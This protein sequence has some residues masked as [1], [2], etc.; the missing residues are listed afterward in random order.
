[1]IHSI[2]SHKLFKNSFVYIATDIVNSAIP[3]LLLPLL[4]T[5]LTPY[6]YGIVSM[7]QVL[8]AVTSILVGLNTN[9]AI[10]VNFFK[11][12]KDDL[13]VYISNVVAICL[14]S[15]L[16]LVVAVLALKPYV[17]KLVDFPENWLLLIAG[18]SIFIVI[19]TINLVLW[20]SE[21]RPLPY[22]LMQI[23]MTTLNLLLSLYFILILEWKWQGRLA[24]IIIANIL[25]GIVSLLFVY[26]RGYLKFSIH[27]AFI[28]DALQIGL[29]LVPHALAGWINSA[30]G[31]VFISS[32]VGMAAT[33]SYTVGYQVGMIM[34][35]LVTS[36]NKA[37]SPFLF[38][39]L[40]EDRPTVNLKI[41]KF[42]YCYLVAVVSLAL[43]LSIITPFLFKL[44]IGKEFQ[45]ASKY[46]AWILLG[47]AAN[48]MY[49]MGGLYLMYIK[50]T[51]IF[52]ATT[53]GAA[54]IN[55][56][57]NY[58]LI[59]FNGPLGAAQAMTITSVI[60]CC[61]IW[62]MSVRAYKMPWNLKLQ[63]KEESC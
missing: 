56:V 33:G 21:Q 58:F 48:G 59:K 16:I 7:G 11:I 62:F 9:T 45:S 55:I 23:A 20:Q 27:R 6:D 15:L 30:I 14:T 47:Y 3:F 39:K 49:Y 63:V 8:L 22:G 24:G 38:Q 40:S 36:F 34:D 46:V 44:F 26:K 5:Y 35:M 4:T 60:T 43:L 53:F 61:A 1:L 10:N 52:A 17:S 41:V 50:R 37:W 54:L 12:N 28:V 29:P 25:I 57:L 42:T 31:R 19:S 32:M 2:L 13:K 18:T 51:K